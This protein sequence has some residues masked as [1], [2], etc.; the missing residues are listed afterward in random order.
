MRRLRFGRFRA[1]IRT[2][3]GFGTRYWR[4]QGNEQARAWLTER[5]KKAGYEI[6]RHTFTTDDALGPPKQVDNLYVTKVGTEHPDAMYMVS[7][8][9]DSINFDSADR[10]FAPGADDDGSGTAA[11]LEMALVFGRGD[12]QVDTSVRFLFWNA[13]EI[14]LVGS[15]AYVEERRTLQGVEEPPGSGNYPE[16]RWLGI[17]QH[18]M[19]LFDHGLPPGSAQIADADIDIEYDADLDFDGGAIAIAAALLGANGRYVNRFPAEVGQFMQSTD[20]VPFAPFCPAVSVRENERRNEI[21]EGANPHWHR[22]SDLPETY[23]TLDYR[24][25]FAALQ[26]TTGAIAELAGA[27]I[28]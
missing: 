24:L 14:G 19:L 15:R 20:S 28:R 9:M 8:H 25:G 11:V 22:D 3:A 17:V 13:E 21:G 2:L 26:T 5:L 6:Q 12:V 4:T 1:S 18:D 27:R 7:A 10:S 23:S 16:P